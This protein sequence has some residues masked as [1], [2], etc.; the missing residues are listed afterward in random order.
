MPCCGGTQCEV[1]KQDIKEKRGG[2]VEG[3][4]L[5]RV[6]R[7]EIGEQSGQRMKGSEVESFEGKE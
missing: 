6:N 2:S 4:E 7:I 1:A 5:R 3:R